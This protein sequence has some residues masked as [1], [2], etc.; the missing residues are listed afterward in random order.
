MV[1]SHSQV[2]WRGDTRVAA[3]SGL[4]A[5]A[6]V[7]DIRQGTRSV[8]NDGVITVAKDTPDRLEIVISRGGS[9]LPRTIV[10]AQRNPAGSG[11]VFLIPDPP[12]RQNLLLYK[13]M[14]TIDVTGNFAMTGVAPGA[15]NCSPGAVFRLAPKKMRSSSSATTRWERTVVVNAGIATA[16]VQVP[17]ISGNR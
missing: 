13:G 15:Y 3:V 17:L 10:D 12:R 2:F 14:T 4:P 9:T 5:D 16:T 7:A 1:T 8:Y 11:Q 6:Y